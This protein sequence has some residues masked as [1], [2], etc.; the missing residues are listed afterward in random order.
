MPDPLVPM[1]CD[2]CQVVQDAPLAQRICPRCGGPCYLH[3]RSVTGEQSFAEFQ[4]SHPP[5][6][7]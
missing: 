2:T 1:R 3:N 4:R 6:A 5:N 7:R